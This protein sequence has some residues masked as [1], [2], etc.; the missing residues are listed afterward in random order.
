LATSSIISALARK[1]CLGVAAF[2]EVVVG[3]GLHDL[4]FGLSGARLLGAR[5]LL[6]GVI[7]NFVRLFV[8]AQACAEVA[9]VLNLVT[10]DQW[11]G[12]QGGKQQQD[13]NNVLQGGQNAESIRHIGGLRGDAPEHQIAA[14]RGRTHI[15]IPNGCATN[16]VHLF[17]A[18]FRLNPSPRR[19]APGAC[20]ISNYSGRDGPAP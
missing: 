17:G 5:R 2:G 8:H 1:P 3:F 16:R 20:T 15:P 19:I 14:R 18:E 12:K 13:G 6:D 4:G 9:P 10:R 11:R 7:E